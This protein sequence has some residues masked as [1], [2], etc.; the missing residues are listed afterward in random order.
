MK[1]M[2][3]S[4]KRLEVALKSLNAESWAT[5]RGKMSD[6]HLVEVLLCDMQ[7]ANDLLTGKPYFSYDA[8]CWVEEEESAGSPLRSYQDCRENSNQPGAIL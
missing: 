1:N 5:E 3:I 7:R 8:Q 4:S 6:A 2:D